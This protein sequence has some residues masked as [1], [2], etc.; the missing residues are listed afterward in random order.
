MNPSEREKWVAVAEFH[1]IADGALSADLAVSKLEGSGIPAMRF[2]SSAFTTGYA[3]GFLPF[4]RVQIVVPPKQ[5]ERAREI[6]DHSE[7]ESGQ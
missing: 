5:A 1:M 4:E 7:Q 6:L 2:P 3:S